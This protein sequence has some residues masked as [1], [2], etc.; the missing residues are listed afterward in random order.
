MAKNTGE[1]KRYAIKHIRDKAKKAYEKDDKCYICLTSD[2]L[3]LHHTHSLTL[4]LKNWAH[5]N[6]HSIETDDEVLAIRD[7]F[8]ETYHKEIYE[9]VYTLCNKHHVALHSV[10]G[11]SPDLASAKKQERW[12][13]IQKAK[14]ADGEQPKGLF[15]SFY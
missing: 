8:I 12:I 14:C 4:L 6:G 10:Y 13:E 9:D 2:N 1:N 3:E 7:E 15:S 5:R 11:K